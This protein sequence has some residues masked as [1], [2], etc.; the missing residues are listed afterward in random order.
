[1]TGTVKN[2]TITYLESL[3]NHHI[4]RWYE[5]GLLV[6]CKQTP[7]HLAAIGTL[8]FC[9]LKKGVKY[10]LQ[11]V[12]LPWKA[13]FDLFTIRVKKSICYLYV[14]A[15]LTAN[16]MSFR[17]V[18]HLCVSWLSHTSTDTSFLFIATNYMCFSHMH[19]S[20]EAKNRRKKICRS[21]VSIPQAPGHKS[22]TICLLT[23][24][25]KS[26]GT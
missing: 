11:S 26:D 2:C 7:F 20:R 6:F 23:V 1:M 15:M 19:Q 10:A 25:M 8:K 17:S 9:P 14:Y 16:H 4:L 18:T 24:M 5:R 12:R 13:E 3:N 22:N 21:R